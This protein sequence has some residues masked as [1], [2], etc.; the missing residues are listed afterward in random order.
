MKTA[1]IL[2]PAYQ[3]THELFTVTTTLLQAE[4]ISSVIIVNDGSDSRHNEL[5][6][7]LKQAGATVLNHGKNQG[8]G[9][10]L[11]TGMNYWYQ[12]HPKHEIGIVTADAD[13]QHA[14]D[15]IIMVA[16][17]LIKSPKALHLGVRKFKQGDIPFRSRFGNILT[18]WVL[19]VAARLN[20]IDTQTGLRGIPQALIYQL[21]QEKESGYELELKM[22]LLTKQMGIKIKQHPIR[23]IYIDDNSSSHFHPVRDSVKIYMVFIKFFSSSILAACIDY[24]VFVLCYYLS[25]SILL[26]GIIARIISSAIN[27]LCNKNF[28]FSHNKKKHNWQDVLKYYILVVI[29]VL[30]SVSLIKGFKTIGIDVYI[31]KII[32]DTLLYFVSFFVQGKLIFNKKKK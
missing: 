11:K 1:C 15:D 31:G 10:A 9:A 25:H 23:T 26:S 4:H 20:L 30:L 5:F 27:F 28:V 3:P 24:G 14:T 6:E 17:K 22:L 2:I 19:K 32:A 21:M 18:A 16:N 13:G 7:Q 8:K 29:I 12:H